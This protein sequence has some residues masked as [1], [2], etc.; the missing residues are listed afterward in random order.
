V[1]DVTARAFGIALLVFLA[2]WVVLYAVLTG[3]AA[4]AGRG[5]RGIP[6]QDVKDATEGAT[7]G[8]S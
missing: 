1:V 5:V 8:P 2:A 4:W 6:E 7:D 3:W